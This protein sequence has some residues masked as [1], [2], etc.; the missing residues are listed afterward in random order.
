METLTPRKSKP[1]YDNTTNTGEYLSASTG[2]EAVGL[3][4]KRN[5]ILKN[6]PT[7]PHI[8][9]SMIILFDGKELLLINPQEVINETNIRNYFQHIILNYTPNNII[10]YIFNSSPN[11]TSLYS[12]FKKLQDSINKE[13]PEVQKNQFITLLRTI[14]SYMNASPSE[15]KMDFTAESELALVKKTEIGTHY[16][17]VGD[18]PN[19]ISYLFVSKSPGIFRS[20]HMENSVSENQIIESFLEG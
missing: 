7:A 9:N 8:K 12:S 14:S 1:Y 15:I 2:S 4:L 18:T 6:N 13:L 20:L 3:A 19:D 16:I 5:S 11:Y 10:K 17:L